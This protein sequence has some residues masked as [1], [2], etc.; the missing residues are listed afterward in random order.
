MEAQLLGLLRLAHKPLG[1]PART[2]VPGRQ[3]DLERRGAHAPDDTRLWAPDREGQ[4][5]E[6]DQEVD[7]IDEAGNRGQKREPRPQRPFQIVT[8]AGASFE[9]NELK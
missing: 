8:E 5:D 6:A 7:G 2:E 3:T 9:E 1:E 4:V